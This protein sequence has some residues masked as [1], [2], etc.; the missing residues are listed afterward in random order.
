MSRLEELYT[1]SHDFLKRYDTGLKFTT[2]KISD[3]GTLS[4]LHDR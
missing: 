2:E 4:D 3:R 1:S